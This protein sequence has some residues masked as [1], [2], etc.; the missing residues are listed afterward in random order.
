MAHVPSSCSQSK[1]FAEGVGY[2]QGDT[3]V[4]YSDGSFTFHGRSDEVS[5]AAEA[6]SNRWSCRI[7]ESVVSNGESKR[8][9]HVPQQK[10]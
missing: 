7:R 2:V 3:A 5:H 1:Y 6:V 4:R 8:R 10:Q 9:S